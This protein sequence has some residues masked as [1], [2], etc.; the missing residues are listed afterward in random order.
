MSSRMLCAILA[1]LAVATLSAD[2]GMWRIGQ[3]PLDAIAKTYGVKLTPQDVERLQ[4]A[5][6]RISSGGTG[7]FASPNGLILTNHHVA[8]DCIRTS[9]LAEQQKGS[10]ANLIEGGFTART[11]SEE[12]P[13]RRF[14]VQIERSS[15]D[16]TTDLNADVK[17]GLSMAQI[18][19]VRQA[20]RGE[21]ERACK[22]ERGASFTCS[23]VDFNSGAF[24]QLIVYE[25]FNDIRLVYAPEKQLGYFGGDEMNFRFPRYVS[26]ISILRAY[27]GSD[28]S[29]GEFNAA[30]VPYRPAHYLRVTLSGVKEG[31]VTFVAGNPGNTNRY[32]LSES[33]VY[34]TSRGM[35]RL[36]QEFE[37]ELALLRKYAAAKPENQVL[38]QERIFGLANTLKYTQDV[39]AALKTSGV[40]SQQQNREREFMESLKA[41]PELQ[42]EYG[43][44]FEDHRKLYAT[45]VE[46]NADLDAALDWLQRASVVSQASTLYEFAQERAKP[47]DRERDPQFQERFWDDLRRALVDDEP[48]I[49][50]L[51]EDV[52]AIGF[53]RALKL[54]AERQ[55][56]AVQSLV[57][58]AGTS[59][60]RALARAVAGASKVA[61]VDF[62]KTLV[63]AAPTVF[64][65][66]SDPA[67]VFARDL[68]PTLKERRARTRVLNETLF[69]HRSK[70]ARG[71][72]EWKGNTLYPD[73]NFT[74]RV[75]YGKVAGYSKGGRPVPFTTRFSDMFALAQARGNR[76]DFELPA[77]LVNWRK[78]IGDPAFN[79]RFANLPVDFV[80]TNDITGGNSG[81]ATL[82]RR[83][84]IVGLIFDGNEEAMASDWAYSEGAGRALSTDIRF[85]LTVAREVH[86]A[87]WI[88]DELVTG[89]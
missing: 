35:P 62:R 40:A 23:V 15:R 10:E 7:T 80:S 6:V 64:E 56:P 54:P 19:Q 78:Q 65:E 73:A 58:R 14:R 67:V 72:V 31:D 1:A 44:L 36:I 38:L 48:L 66:S 71:L 22:Q 85:A 52:L 11:M 28:G 76:G 17:P 82:N 32:R 87:G 2:E 24:S 29:H 21:I 25:D 47:S 43:I 8:L 20:K 12:L 9:T 84:E 41:R 68:L 77:A 16:V 59:D 49:T 39:L 53:E 57:R 61:G 30:N 79:Q 69:Q 13:C 46:A 45:A 75:T 89:R 5:P 63:E 70:F 26:D 42:K 81:S 33:A 86:G 3:L 88:V 34:N 74:L 50:E 60:P 55:V 4:N 51:E 37:T 83:L 27:V 18:Q